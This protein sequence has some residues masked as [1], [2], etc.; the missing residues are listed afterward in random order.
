M[1]ESETDDHYYLIEANHLHAEVTIDSDHWK[2]IP[3]VVTHIF[4]ALNAI[5]GDEELEIVS[6]LLTSDEKIQQL[7]RDFRNMDKPTNVLSFPSDEDDYI[8]DIAIAYETL[9]REAKEQ[10]KDF[11]HHFIHMLIH[12][13]L[14]LYGYDHMNDNDAEKMESLEIKILADM[15]IENPYI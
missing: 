9:E 13:I 10:D 7:N 2:S 14:H 3:D 1:T 12:G 6:I 11:I 8:G 15:G 5:Q 4:R